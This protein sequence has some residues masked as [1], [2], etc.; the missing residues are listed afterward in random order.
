MARFKTACAAS[1]DD[2][3]D[4]SVLKAALKCI[5]ALHASYHEGKNASSYINP[6]SAP[7][8]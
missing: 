2:Y 6:V 5:S 3:C 7:T 4:V 8:L 1:Q